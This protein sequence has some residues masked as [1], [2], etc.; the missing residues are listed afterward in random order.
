MRCAQSKFSHTGRY[1][2]A[3]LIGSA[4]AAASCAGVGGPGTGS[5]EPLSWSEFVQRTTPAVGRSGYIV[6]HDI[7]LADLDAMHAYYDAYLAQELDGMALGSYA[8]SSGLRPVPGQAESVS[9]QA[10]T[11]DRLNGFDDIW[12]GPARFALTYCISNN[13]GSDTRQAKNKQAVISAL[14]LATRSWDAVVNVKFAYVPGEDANCTA[15]N[16]NVLFDVEPISNSGFF[17]NSFFPRN[18]A[19]Q[20]RRLQID[21]SAFTTTAGGR[22]LQGIMRHELG[23]VLGFRHEHIWLSPSCTGEGSTDARPVT[24][25]DV[26]SVMHYPQCRPSGNG[27]YRQT[28][29]DFGGA[30]SLYGVTPAVIMASQMPIH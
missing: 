26:N 21:D 27:G 7:Y 8:Y 30:T 25:Y 23:H 28:V 9:E 14:A 29:L 11:V 12:G 10:L 24:A 1:A 3:A 6:D 15:S 16:T 5:P 17:A 19:R 18:T 22:D 2:T 20:D 13:F 4:I